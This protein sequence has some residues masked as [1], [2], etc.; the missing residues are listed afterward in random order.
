M[1]RKKKQKSIIT[2]E[3]ARVVNGKG[4][5]LFFFFFKPFSVGLLFPHTEISVILRR[6]KKKVN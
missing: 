1:K 5:W 3:K 4:K 6:K 2:I